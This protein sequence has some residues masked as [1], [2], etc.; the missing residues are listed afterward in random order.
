MTFNLFFLTVSVSKRNESI[1][2]IEHY[3]RV[4][5]MIDSMKD[6]QFLTYRS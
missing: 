5:K 3:E 4:T 6:R 1:E 2:E